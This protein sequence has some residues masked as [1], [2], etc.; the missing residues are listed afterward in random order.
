MEDYLDFTFKR[1]SKRYSIED[2]ENM[3]LEDD[4]YRKFLADMR[5]LLQDETKF[6]NLYCEVNHIKSRNCKV[7]DEAGEVSYYQ[8][9][10]LSEG[11]NNDDLGR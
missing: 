2:S 4:V 8:K 5:E 11:L 10:N 6:K 3:F 1:L 9:C 7:C